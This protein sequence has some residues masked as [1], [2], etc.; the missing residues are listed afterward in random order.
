MKSANVITM[1]IT[2]I[3]NMQNIDSDGSF[4]VLI[5]CLVIIYMLLRFITHFHVQ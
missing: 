1:M 5:L 4:C 3:L 2:E